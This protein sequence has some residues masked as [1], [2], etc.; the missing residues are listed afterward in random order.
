MTAR[1]DIRIDVTGVV[2]IDASLET[3]AWVY[4]PPA[5]VKVTCP[6]VVLAFPGG[7]YSRS[8]YDLHVPGREGYSFAEHLARRGH[9][10]VSCEHIGLGD[11]TPYEPFADLTKDVVVKADLAT[12]KGVMARLTTGT[13]V[14]GLGP[15]NNPFM[16]GVGHS[17]GARLLTLQQGRYRSFDA[18]AI[19]GSSRLPLKTT[20]KALHR[21]VQPLAKFVMPDPE[22]PPRRLSHRFFHDKDVPD[23]V[24]AADDALAV[25]LYPWM[26][27]PG[28]SGILGD[29][30][31]P[32]AARNV[33]VPVFLGF[34]ARD[35]SPDPHR[36]AQAYPNS[37]DITI[38]VLPRS[39]HCTN[40]AE[41]R[42]LFFN[43]I[44]GWCNEV[45]KTYRPV[46]RTQASSA[47]VSEAQSTGNV[48]PTS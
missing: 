1:I 26:S 23:D 11:S 16:I 9:I 41:T 24:K 6:T 14:E 19:L 48:T 8:Y 13:L 4:L 18:I 20:T 22:R 37:P 10:V 47:N 31:V 27:E 25:R 39:A 38:F 3:A 21:I 28:S 36:E 15:L 5:D 40:L 17:I 30:A 45:S 35:V 44:S 12:V 43:R 29:P 32:E 33:D 2:P 46:T 34:G 42:G 7:S